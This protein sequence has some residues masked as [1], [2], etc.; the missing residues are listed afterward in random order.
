[1]VSRKELYENIKI[2]YPNIPND[3]I[4]LLL[5]LYTNDKDWLDSKIKEEKRK[6]KYTCPPKPK[7]QLSLEEVE[8]LNEKF[9][10][11]PQGKAWVEDA[12]EE[13]NSDVIVK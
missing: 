12:S 6:N 10:D 3:M 4:F 8:K 5:D 7:T 13:K 1:M 9:K 11:I 2:D